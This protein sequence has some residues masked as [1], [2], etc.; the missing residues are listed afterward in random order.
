MI[1]IFDRFWIECQS[2]STY[3]TKVH[4]DL[5]VKV[6]PER[7]LIFQWLFI[8]VNGCKGIEGTSD[9]ENFAKF[10]LEKF[11]TTAI[12]VEAEIGKVV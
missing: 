1:F 6:E 10:I 3:L 11:F 2:P 9:L 12:V 7:M 5:I 8:V 4:A